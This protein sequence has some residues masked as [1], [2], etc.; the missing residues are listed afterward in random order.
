MSKANIDTSNGVS[1]YQ[2][3]ST[4]G[5]ENPLSA[6]VLATVI[7]TKNYYNTDSISNTLQLMED[8][9]I[10]VL[11][12]PNSYW[13]D[14]IMI[15]PVGNITRGWFP[16]SHTKPYT[17]NDNNN[18]ISKKHSCHSP[19]FH[20]EKNTVNEFEKS[21][22]PRKM[23]IMSTDSN[24]I[25][26]DSMNHLDKIPPKHYNN[27]NNNIN[28]T[29]NTNT[30]KD[31]SNSTPLATNITHSPSISLHKAKRLSLKP[32]HPHHLQYQNH[33]QYYISKVPSS[34]SISDIHNMMHQST[35]STLKH[36]PYN[37]NHHHRDDPHSNSHSLSSSAHSIFKE[38][39]YFVTKQE[40]FSSANSNQYDSRQ[41]SQAFTESLS[42][43]IPNCFVS[44]DEVNSYFQP[45]KS[46]LQPSFNFIPVW[47]PQFDQNYNTVYEN[48]ALNVCTDEIPFIDSG[49]IN[50][51]TL[52][53]SPD[54]SNLIKDIKQ[55]SFNLQGRK[56]SEVSSINL[57]SKQNS[58]GI[59]SN[60][61]NSNFNSHSSS[62]NT[63]SNLPSKIQSISDSTS[64]NNMK[65]NPNY[66][67]TMYNLPTFVDSRPTEIF[68][69]HNT[70]I[71]SYDTFNSSFINLIDKCIS[72]LKNHD[73][74]NYNL[75]MNNTA[76]FFSLYHLLGRLIRQKLIDD[77]QLR[78]FSIIL[79]K[80]TKMFIQFKIWASLSVITIDKIELF[81]RNLNETLNIIPSDN[82]GADFKQNSKKDV[83][84]SKNELE[85]QN[86]DVI[87][88]KNL[89]YHNQLVE[90]YIE[91]LI[92]IRNKIEKLSLHL[93]TVLSKLNL[94]PLNDSYQP[95]NSKLLPMLYPRFIKNKFEAGNFKNKFVDLRTTQND[96]F[97]NPQQKVSNILLD[98]NAISKLETLEK[99]IHVSLA[100]FNEILSMKL[101]N[102][103]SLS[104]FLE[105][106][107]LKLLTAVYQAIPLL[108]AFV[109]LVESIDLTVFAMIDKLAVKH[110]ETERNDTIVSKLDSTYGNES[111]T[112][113]DPNSANVT[114]SNF[115]QS[116]D[117]TFSDSPMISET[118]RFTEVSDENEN[119]QS[120]YDATAKVFRPMIQ[121]FIHLKQSIHSV[122]T[123]LILDA[124][125]ITAI[126]PESFFSIKDD[127]NMSISH[128]NLK[129]LTESLNNNP[130]DRVKIVADVML[131]RFENLDKNSLNDGVFS[132]EPSLKL[133]ET[134][135]LTKNRIKLV[136]M[137]I[138]QLK[139]ER[140]LILNYCTRLMNTDFNVAS[141]F[142]A[143]RHNT[144][145]P[146][147]GDQSQN[148]NNKSV[149]TARSVSNEIYGEHIDLN[150]D[151]SNLPT[152]ELNN[153]FNGGSI[154]SAVE[155]MN[156]NLLEANIYSN[157][158]WYI[159]PDHNEQKL[160]F[161]GTVLRGGPIKGLIAKLINPLNPYDQLYEETFLCF[162]AT[163]IKP[164]KLFETLIDKY[165]TNMPEAL[166]YEEYGIWL[167]QKLKPQQRKVLEI[168]EKLFAK[169][170]MVAY[171]SAELI[172]TWEIFLD[173]LPSVDE[174]LIELSSKVLSFTTQQ[175]YIDFIEGD[176][177]KVKSLP[178]SQL[179]NNI[180]HLK[181]QSL[182]ISYVAEQITAMQSFYY[183]QLNLWDLLGRSYNYNRIFK[184]KSEKINNLR[185]PLG[186]KNVANFIKNCNNLTHYTTF[187]ILKNSSLEKRVEAIKYFIALAE[188][189]L[190]M[191]NF[192]SM[193]AII[194]G[195]GSTSISRLKKTWDLVPNN[196]V[197]KLEKMDNLMSIGKNYSEYRNILK[198]VETDGDAYLPFLGMYLSDLRF[199][200]DGNPDWL[201]NKKGSKGIVNFSKRI[202][203][204]KIIKEVV[205]YNNNLHD[206][207]LDPEFSRY[208]HEMF[209]E[210]PDDEKL[211]EL[212]IEIEPRVSLLKNTNNAHEGTQKSVSSIN[213]V[214]LNNI[215]GGYAGSIAT[216]S[217]SKTGNDDKKDRT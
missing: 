170:W 56:N 96:F 54:T 106:K 216:A 25:Q 129:I 111:T 125:T 84:D 55:L 198:F 159:G 199:T 108:S 43:P 39:N 134:I 138:S 156:D 181:L 104:V 98:E 172:N 120:F 137:S 171:T 33:S 180:L 151:Y 11:D 145:T 23:S 139:E 124:Q 47:I 184:K 161:E 144:L 116:K 76:T 167:E 3:P 40:S 146:K 113:I 122:F 62:T 60:I 78:K 103:A 188:Q 59:N 210:L 50:E 201:G 21:N 27:N 16:A 147:I 165:Y 65:S 46:E 217:S 123:D 127:N 69:T 73:K 2:N 202:S 35:V 83:S 90:S 17:K 195:L 178:I 207:K 91:D 19:I 204:M 24:I 64:S 185:D 149:S 67:N 100:S 14:G 118:D 7:S 52:Y 77:N 66:F 197:A 30:N 63:N 102:D 71:L 92:R 121:D 215:F 51:K 12:K 26:E 132:I 177:K 15:D 28:T 143:E 42:N 5:S 31:V 89:N 150:N 115:E 213:T 36:E 183:Q 57:S 4:K 155:N 166:S 162:F 189:L 173:D 109:D 203:I 179:N 126:D 133:L 44:N 79:K 99:K 212:S 136:V 49:Y 1:E 152:N 114:N 29:T 38:K 80:I 9:L 186:T 18:N 196:F 10:Y 61:N 157:Y 209:K 205:S 117:E 97:I 194:S 164:I 6:K 70:D 68:Y 105:E 211:Y 153:Y 86:D 128:S 88:D 72:H 22:N 141:L 93:S 95:N 182:D 101:D 119:S 87:T 191:K 176:N 200:T 131:K 154:D 74:L 142:I 140:R 48:K 110:I 135:K 169:F 82:I 175:E 58:E 168:F 85:I 148:Y 75:V 81:E 94:N 174:S 45:S 41:S 13:W 112:S 192:S 214:D 8:D 53:E 193:T 20:N 206:I 34:K 187:M 160:I 107:N 130:S 158:P 37:I 163:F 208:M 32:K 190:R